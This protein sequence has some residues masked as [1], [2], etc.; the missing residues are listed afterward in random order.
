M[1]RSII[2]I[3]S[4]LLVAAVLYACE[5]KPLTAPETSEAFWQAVIMDDRDSVVAYSTLINVEDY[6]RFGRQWQ[7]LSP[8]WGRIVIN[9]NAAQVETEIAGP[10]AETTDTLYF[11]TYLVNTDEGWRVDYQRTADAVSVS[12]AVVDFVGQLTTLGQNIQRQVEASSDNVARQMT[13]FVE[14]LEQMAG[15]YQDH[16][17]QAIEAAAGRMRGLLDEFV[18]SLEEAI[19]ELDASGDEEQTGATEA[20]RAE[21]KA[22]VDRLQSSGDALQNPTVDSIATSGEQFIAV[23]ARLDR[24]SD[25]K[26]QHYTRRWEQLAEEFM[27]EL[28]NLIALFTGVDQPVVKEHEQNETK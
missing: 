7:G 8:T 2:R 9:G 13:A 14:Q 5:R 3:I 24:L 11:L 10:D 25:E 28:A 19:D 16:A 15:E 12:G 26:L 6:D 4:L 22:S 1:H 21:M 18:R 23:M 27:A 20:N 17:D